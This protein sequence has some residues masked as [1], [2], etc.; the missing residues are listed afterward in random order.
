MAPGRSADYRLCHAPG[1]CCLAVGSGGG[2]KTFRVFTGGA[3]GCVGALA[4]EAAADSV[5]GVSAASGQRLW[6]LEAEGHGVQSSGADRGVLALDVSP[7]GTLLVTADEA[8]SVRLL[9][10]STGQLVA[11]LA[12]TPIPARAVRF[13]PTGRHVAV[14]GGEPATIRL[15]QV[16]DNTHVQVLRPAVD[17]DAYSSVVENAVVALEFDALG[18]LM[19]TVHEQ[20]AWP[21]TGGAKAGGKAA[22]PNVCLWSVDTQRPLAYGVGGVQGACAVR[23]SPDGA[24]WAIG[25]AAGKVQVLQ[26]G[27][28]HDA[29]RYTFDVAA[30][31]AGSERSGH[32]A[33]TPAV[34]VHALAW[35]VHSAARLVAAVGDE[36]GEIGGALVLCDLPSART[37]LITETDAAVLDIEWSP[38]IRTVF[39]VDLLGQLGAAAVAPALNNTHWNRPGDLAAPAAADA[40]NDGALIVE[41]LE[42]AVL[43]HHVL[44]TITRR[45]MA[46]AAQR[47]RLPHPTTNARSSPLRTF[48]QSD[49]LIGIATAPPLACERHSSQAPAWISTS[50][51]AFCSGISSAASPAACMRAARP[52]RLP[53]AKSTSSSPTPPAARCVSST[54]GRSRWPLWANTPPALRPLASA[55]P[56][57]PPHVSSIGRTSRGHPAANGRG[58]WTTTNSRWRW[59][60]AS[61]GWRS[62]PA[63]NKCGCSPSPDCPPRP[64]VRAA[65]APC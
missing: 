15:V 30:V 36:R 39:Y 46:T 26:R 31:V 56:C 22:A 33:S 11:M 48:P 59:P 47:R 57:P 25:D 61:C 16:A 4:Y 10:A 32:G 19:A 35:D 42:R 53:D 14:A 34:R 63:H 54:A 50:S 20:R 2:S 13:S 49:P 41:H 23:A 37:T 21:P 7:C 8:C 58:T 24:Y 28:W 9:E 44:E 18:E 38:E 55:P 43:A 40:P 5:D 27:A 17:D 52:A 51:A 65:P 62:P 12:R 1:Q 3:D 64:S 60:W 45:A 6:H 29:P